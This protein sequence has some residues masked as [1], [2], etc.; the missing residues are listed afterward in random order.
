MKHSRQ[1]L[2]V[3]DNKEILDLISQFLIDDDY[4]V[5]TASNSREMKKIMSESQ[6]H[7]VLLGLRLPDDDGLTLCRKIRT[8]SNI[9][10]IIL[11]AKCDEIDRVIGLEMGADDCVS[12]PFGSREL[13][14]RIKAV[15][16]RTY[17]FSS[18]ENTYEKPN[19]YNFDTWKIDTSKRELISK[20]NVIT[21]LSTGEFTLLIAFVERPQRVL[22]RDQLLIIARG[23]SSVIFDRSIDTQVSRLRR[24]I[25]IDPK[26]PK[27]VKTVWGGGY[28][29]TPD[30]IKE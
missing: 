27:I 19:F 14:A 22:S 16:R 10:I 17:D 20:D 6:I 29:F 21:P 25:E 30:V 18:P 23:R 15:I 1:I 9:P 11:T 12:K 24:K 5:L 13:L 2:I 7:L 8:N 28:I 3:D 4:H 26:K